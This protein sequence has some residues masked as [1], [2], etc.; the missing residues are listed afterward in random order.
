[1]NLRGKKRGVLW[2]GAMLLL[3]AAVLVALLPAAREPVYQG[4]KLGVWL[5][6]VSGGN[7]QIAPTS[8]LASVQAVGADALPWLL[9]ELEARDWQPGEHPFREALGLMP[10]Q[11][12]RSEERRVGKECIPPCRSRWSPYH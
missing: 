5:D 9:A 2:A 4:R 3:V 11:G 1:M 7:P 8:A 10:L 6:A 12:R